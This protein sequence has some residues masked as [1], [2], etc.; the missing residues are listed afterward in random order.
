MQETVGVQQALTLQR[1]C[2]LLAR[3]GFEDLLHFGDA[4]TPD[5]ARTRSADGS[6]R[7]LSTLLTPV[8]A[9]C[10]HSLGTHLIDIGH[11]VVD[12]LPGHFCRALAPRGR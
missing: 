2:E 11:S 10:L 8:Q 12:V 3:D 9:S 1:G 4:D 5:A 7:S 6:E